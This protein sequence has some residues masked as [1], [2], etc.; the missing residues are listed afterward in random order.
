MGLLDKHS[1]AELGIGEATVNA[2]RTRQR[3]ATAGE[4]EHG[5]A[6]ETITY[7]GNPS[8]DVRVPS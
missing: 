8:V 3:R 7:S 2:D 6:A 5:H 1:A 4:F